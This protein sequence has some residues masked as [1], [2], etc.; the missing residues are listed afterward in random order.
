[1]R[2]SSQIHFEL[3]ELG[4]DGPACVPAIEPCPEIEAGRGRVITG[5]FTT[6]R[7]SVLEL[8]LSN[9]EALEPTPPHRFYSDT[10]KDWVA[11]GDLRVGECLRTASGQAVTVESI[12]LKAGEHRVYNLEVEQEHQFYVGETGVLTHNAYEF[13]PRRAEDGL[14]PEELL[15]DFGKAPSGFVQS[16]SGRQT[17]GFGVWR[18]PQS[19]NKLYAILSSGQRNST[20]PPSAYTGKGGPRI[21]G[22]TQQNFHHPEMQMA[23]FMRQNPDIA[24]A[25]I[26]INNPDGPCSGARG[27]NPNLNNTLLPNQTLTVRLKGTDQS[28]QF[29]QAAK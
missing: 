20:V 29:G 4:I 24:N 5:T 10:R 12:G 8:R 11:A 23:N 2:K 3:A 22:V 14:N 1:M 21:P 18:D 17:S 26:W 15:P 28:W 7:C 13:K 9:G 19:G 16:S 6:A 27:C 25:D